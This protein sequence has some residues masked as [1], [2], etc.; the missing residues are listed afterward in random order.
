MQASDWIALA[1]VVIALASI[2]VA[3]WQGW[4]TREHN[5]K[6]SVA[7]L[8]FSFSYDESQ[9]VAPF[10]LTLANA[11]SGPA[12][13]DRIDLLLDGQPFAAPKGH[14]WPA[15]WNSAGCTGCRFLFSM[16]NVGDV[17]RPGEAIPLVAVEHN[18][19]Y[20][21]EV[22]MF[23]AALE[24]IDLGIT[25]RSVY[26]ERGVARLRSSIGEWTYTPTPGPDLTVRV[27]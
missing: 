8:S 4:E 25:Y 6:S 11:G 20:W 7:H 14:P 13:I 1:A 5:R 12:I 21:Q 26:D 19:P 23:A 24:R 27:I 9:T 2:V 16:P 3:V 15:V 18:K 10:G 17:M 22:E